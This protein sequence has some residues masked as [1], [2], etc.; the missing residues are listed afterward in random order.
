MARAMDSLVVSHARGRS[1]ALTPTASEPPAASAGDDGAPRLLTFGWRWLASYF[2]LY[3]LPWPIGWLPGS[4]QLAA[5]FQTGRDWLLL[6]AGDV[7]LQSRERLAPFPTGSGDTTRE[8]LWLVLLAACSL[9][10]AVTWSLFDRRP[11]HPRLADLLRTYL[12]YVLAATLLGYG[13]AKFFDGQFP[14]LSLPQMVTSWGDSS[15]M[16]VLW[17]F[18]GASPAYT[19]ASGVVECLGGL[20][21][22]WRRTALLGAL[23]VI[24]AMSNVVLLNFCY[25][26]PVKAYSTHLLVMAVLVAAHDRARLLAMLWLHRALPAQPLRSPTP[27]WWFWP[28]RL[29]KFAVVGW[30]LFGHGQQLLAAWHRVRSGPGPLELGCEVIEFERDGVVV[31]PLWTDG[32]RWRHLLVRDRGRDDER[33]LRL[34]VLGPNGRMLRSWRLEPSTREHELLVEE[35]LPPGQ[36]GPAPLQSW[37]LVPR[38]AN[39]GGPREWTLDG[40]MLGAKVHA[41]LRELRPADLPLQQRGFHWVQELPYNR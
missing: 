21:L 9:A 6:H 12:R 19:A 26:V 5:R 20:L 36:S 33:S 18:M 15:P 17:R 13:T 27:R 40:T 29:L 35:A 23:V 14:S 24:V 41:V 37:L 39:A 32:D 34:M 16:G 28:S 30:L 8:W 10:I 31:P 7:L 11:R 2:V 22:L 38:P 1:P 3:N 4:D 25:D